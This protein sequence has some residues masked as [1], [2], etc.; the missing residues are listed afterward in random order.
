MVQSRGVTDPLKVQNWWDAA[1]SLGR[2]MQ[3]L[4]APHGGIEVQLAANQ[5]HRC[6][7]AFAYGGAAGVVMI[8]SQ[9]A[10]RLGPISLLLW[11]R[12]LLSQHTVSLR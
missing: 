5:C 10:A 4:P 11:Q 12:V 9:Y 7:V 3:V 2:E 1:P 6:G 8:G